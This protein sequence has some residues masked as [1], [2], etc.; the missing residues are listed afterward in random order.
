MIAI[1][2]VEVYASSTE[3]AL[4]VSVYEYSIP[5]RCCSPQ[6]EVIVA[7]FGDA[8]GETLQVSQAADIKPGAGWDFQ[9]AAP[10]LI[11]Q[12]LD[13]SGEE[14]VGVVLPRQVVIHAV[15]LLVQCQHLGEDDDLRQFR[16]A[17][18]CLWSPVVG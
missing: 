12:Q 2:A 18:F 17:R 5:G 13:L 6:K 8:V 15:G 1:G 7:V 16:T 10:R 4:N 3:N 11:A 9:H 14:Q